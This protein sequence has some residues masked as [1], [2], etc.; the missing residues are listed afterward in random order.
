MIVDASNESALEMILSDVTG[1]VLYTN[2]TFTL[3]PLIV[4]GDKPTVTIQNST[5]GFTPSLILNSQLISFWQA[6]MTP[7]TI[8]VDI[9]SISGG[10]GIPSTFHATLI[11]TDT[12]KPEIGPSNLH[13]LSQQTLDPTKEY[14]VSVQ[15]PVKS[16]AYF[17][18]KVLLF[19]APSS[20]VAKSA[21]YTLADWQSVQGVQ[22][23]TLT[24]VAGAVWKGMIPQQASGAKLYW[25]IYVVNYAGIETLQVGNSTLTYSM[26]PTTELIGGYV[27]LGLI[28]FGIIFAVSYRVQQGV[29]TVK[30]AKKVA[31]PGKKA[32]AEKAVPGAGKKTPISKD[33]PTKICPICKAR[34]GADS[35]ECPYCHKKFYGV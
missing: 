28:F 1:S 7:A 8:Y 13:A 9:L 25:A 26:A 18:R 24:L 15:V 34:I 11:V 20:P 16:G 32:V 33:I 17:T 6:G 3:E 22:N 35:T 4:I 21:S 23:V 27:F 14:E 30:K 19:L 2:V 12:Q 31:A 10:L 5:G 29:Q